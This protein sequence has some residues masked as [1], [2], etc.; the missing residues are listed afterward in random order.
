M[1]ARSAEHVS[2]S[3]GEGAA[4]LE[5]RDVDRDRLELRA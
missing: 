5:G 3:R 4:G 2:S 1:L